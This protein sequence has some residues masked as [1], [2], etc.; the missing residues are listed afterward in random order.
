MRSFRPIPVEL[1]HLCLGFLE[2]DSNVGKRYCYRL[3]DNMRK[4]LTIGNP[5]FEVNVLSLILE[6]NIHESLGHV[7]WKTRL[8]P[9]TYFYLKCTFYIFFKRKIAWGSSI[10]S[11]DNYVPIHALA[12]EVW[13]EPIQIKIPKRELPLASQAKQQLNELGSNLQCLD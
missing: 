8:Q 11:V 3:M 10:K 9:N 5:P 7:Q 1:P 12:R 2:G 4:L 13:I 6:G